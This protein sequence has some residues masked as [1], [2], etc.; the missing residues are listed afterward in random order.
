MDNLTRKAQE[1]TIS[2]LRQFQNVHFCSISASDSNLDTS[3]YK[4]ALLWPQAKFIFP[5][6]DPR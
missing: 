3:T 4:G 6:L 2:T 5:T 1:L